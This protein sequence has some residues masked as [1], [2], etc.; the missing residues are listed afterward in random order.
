MHNYFYK[1]RNLTVYIDRKGLDHPRKQKNATPERDELRRSPPRCPPEQRISVKNLPYK[2]TDQ[3]LK[4]L[5]RD[6]VGDVSYVE[7]YSD[8]NGK[9]RQMWYLVYLVVKFKS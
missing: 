5:F 4:D 2:M 8:E 6:R 1:G 7:L 9:V 3:E